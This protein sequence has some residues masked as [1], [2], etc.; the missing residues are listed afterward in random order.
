M[1]SHVTGGRTEQL[2]EKKPRDCSPAA[3]D[4]VGQR[5]YFALNLCT[6]V[7]L[8]VSLGRSTTEGNLG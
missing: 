5:S 7:L 4:R 2:R 6:V 1:R 3:L 8:N